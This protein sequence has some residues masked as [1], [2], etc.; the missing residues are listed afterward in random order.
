MP[1]FGAFGRPSCRCIA[2]LSAPTSTRGS[3]ELGENERP[4]GWEVDEAA[5]LRPEEFELMAPDAHDTSC[6]MAGC[7]GPTYWRRDGY[8][9][10]MHCGHELAAQDALP[11]AP[12]GHKRTA[13]RAVSSSGLLAAGLVAGAMVFSLTSSAPPSLARPMAVRAS[14]FV[15]RDLIALLRNGPA[16]LEALKPLLR[17]DDIEALA[18]AD[19]ATVRSANTIANDWVNFHAETKRQIALVLNDLA[20][21]PGVFTNLRLPVALLLGEILLAGVELEPRALERLIE[22][23]YVYCGGVGATSYGIGVLQ[24]VGNVVQGYAP[25]EPRLQQQLRDFLLHP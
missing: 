18:S 16:G 12:E 4:D 8:R 11:S 14:A 21:D 17:F 1:R 19:P 20:A 24:A 7:G 23:F 6:P 10:C 9:V 5:R 25:A 3:E 2:E 15:D 22:N 13:S